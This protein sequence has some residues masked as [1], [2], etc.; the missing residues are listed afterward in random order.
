MSYEDE[1]E[2]E[3][4]RPHIPRKGILDIFHFEETP[5]LLNLQGH[6]YHPLGAANLR[7][8][9]GK[10]GMKSST[11]PKKKAGNS[12]WLLP[13]PESPSLNPSHLHRFN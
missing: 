13:K 5:A 3:G 8:R 11:A 2:D 6:D 4:I 9:A 12:V 10:E 7:I 1:G